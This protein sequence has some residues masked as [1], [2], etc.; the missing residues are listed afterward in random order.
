MQK[1]VATR[2]HELWKVE[3]W[4]LIRGALE[5]LEQIWNERKLMELRQSDSQP[6]SPH[7]TGKFDWLDYLRGKNEELLVL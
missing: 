1:W 2:F 6:S 4:G 5:V 7:E 3:P